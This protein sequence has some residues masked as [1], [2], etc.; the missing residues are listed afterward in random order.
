MK[1]LSLALIALSFS[2]AALADGIGDRVAV[3][4]DAEGDTLSLYNGQ[5]VCE[6]SQL[7]AILSMSG[8][9][10]NGCW[11]ANMKAKVVYVFLVDTQ[12][13]TWYLKFSD[14]ELTEQGKFEAGI[15]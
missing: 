3:H 14:F 5:G 11:A 6:S 12:S 7:S 8:K 4:T 1:A 2:A 15:K 9:L 10:Y 13:P